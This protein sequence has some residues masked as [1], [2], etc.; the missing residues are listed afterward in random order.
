MAAPV[1]ACDQT[2]ILSNPV[3][4][5]EYQYNPVT[6]LW[7]MTASWYDPAME[8]YVPDPDDYT[9]QIGGP[10]DPGGGGGG[11]TNP[12]VDPY[13]GGMRATIRSGV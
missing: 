13:S 5:A 10:A 4:V 8:N 3:N 12:P 7:H 6:G 1:S 9:F 2:N 11:G